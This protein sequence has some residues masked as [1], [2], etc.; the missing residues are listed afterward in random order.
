MC[1]G[2]CTFECR[3][4]RRPE[5]VALLEL[6]LQLTWVLGVKLRSSARIAYSFKHGA[7]FPAPLCVYLLIID[8]HL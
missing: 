7:T 3:C 1:V 4:R 8:L 6:E 2:L 5:T